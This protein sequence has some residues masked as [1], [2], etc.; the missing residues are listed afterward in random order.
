MGVFRDFLCDIS[1]CF[2]TPIVLSRYLAQL[3]LLVFEAVSPISCAP[4]SAAFHSMKHGFCVNAFCYVRMGFAWWRCELCPDKVSRQGKN[5]NSVLMRSFYVFMSYGN[6]KRAKETN[7]KLH[8]ANVF[9]L[10]I[11]LM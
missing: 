11:V 9:C 7:I 8:C 3:W 5:E 10:S 4:S 2:C 6:M 1:Y